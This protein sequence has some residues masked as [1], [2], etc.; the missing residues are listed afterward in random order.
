MVKYYLDEDKNWGVDIDDM[1]K[2][3]R[4]AKDLGI[5]VRAMTVIN[6]GNPTG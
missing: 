5:R 1:Q 6:P 4:D 3:V 2:R